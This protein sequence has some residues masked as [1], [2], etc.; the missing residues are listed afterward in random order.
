MTSPNTTALPDALTRIQTRPLFVMRLTALPMQVIGEA[1]T[2]HRRVA[3]VTGGTFEGE[4]LS[5][6]VLDGGNDWQR[7]RTD[8]SIGLDV[9]IVLQTTDGAL[10]GMTYT[11]VRHGPADV[12]D[13]L[14]RGET[15]DPKEYYFRT[16]A[17]F[18]TAAPGYAWINKIIAIGTGHRYPEGPVY[19]LFEVL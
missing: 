14:N 4:R 15:V 16:T 17:Q 13:R 11:G 9:R 12:L 2:G 10:I 7:I 8:A 19:A 6:T 3:A 18:E 5:G 1:P